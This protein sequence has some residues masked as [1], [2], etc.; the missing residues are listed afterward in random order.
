MNDRRIQ[1]TPPG[2]VAA[3]FLQDNSFF[4][5]IMGPF[6]SGKSSTCVVEVLK[7]SGE[8]AP[9][10]VDGIRK[11]RWAIV[12]N[13]YPELKTTTLKTWFQWCP[14]E[15]GKCNFDSPITHHVRA[16]GLDME[17]L[18]IALD[19]EDDVKKLLSLELTGIFFNECREIPKAIIDAG[20]ARVGRY[21]PM[22]EGGCSWSGVICDTNPPDDQNWYYKAAEEE[23]PKNWKFFRQPGGRAPNAENLANLPKNYYENIVG[24]KDPDWVSV[25]VDAEYGF[26]TEGKAVFP[27]FRDRIH[28]SDIKLEPIKGIPVLAGADFGLTPSITFG[29]KLADGQWLILRTLDADNC[30]IIRFAEMCV[31]FFEKEFPDHRTPECCFGDP[32]GNQRAQSDERTALDIMREHTGWKWRP[33]PSNDIVIRREVVV[34]ALSRLIDGKAGFLLCPSCAM[35]RKGMSGGYHYKYVKTSNGAQLHE[36][37]NKNQY[38]HG[39]DSLQYLIL[40][41]GDHHSIM[42]RIQRKTGR[43]HELAAG[44]EY[45]V[46]S[47]RVVQD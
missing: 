29:Q 22:N 6:G 32:S 46:F 43:R 33:A 12:R 10:T 27:M 17:V 9:S 20:T 28:T 14:K 45:D 13:S 7:R 2:P 26:I 35:L 31:T 39:A 30:G 23:T 37:P 38:S 41:G 44:M 25:Y 19:K 4:R 21:P 18:F 11:T 40:G 34:A 24:G 1:Y 36:T 42:N 8:Q 15:F 47:G 5:A 3:A 16:E